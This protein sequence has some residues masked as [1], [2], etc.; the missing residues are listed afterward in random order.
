MWRTARVFQQ[1]KMVLEVVKKGLKE[2]K[3]F[4]FTNILLTKLLN[5]VIFLFFM[6]VTK[7]K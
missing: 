2:Q 4:F 6:E 7:I 1:K 5:R 3:W